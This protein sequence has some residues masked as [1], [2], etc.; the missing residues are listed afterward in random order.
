MKQEAEM[1]GKAPKD[2]NAAPITP[3][4]RKER[5]TKKGGES[6]QTR[7]GEIG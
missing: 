5:P 3:I 6:L 2:A 7:H 4:S 1:L